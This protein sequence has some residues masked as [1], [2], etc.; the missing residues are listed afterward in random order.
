MLYWTNTQNAIPIIER[1]HL[2]GSQREIIVHSDLLQLN[3][4]DLDVME[5]MIYWAEDLRNG[6]FLIERSFVNGSGR[7]EFYRGLGHFIASL[8]VCQCHRFFN[9]ILVLHFV[10]VFIIGGRGL[11]ILE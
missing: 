9:L 3:A 1:S 8:T 10:Y 2:N 11:R 4:F 6:Y 5:Q 7:E